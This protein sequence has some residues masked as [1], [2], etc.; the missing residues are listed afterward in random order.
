M[1]TWRSQ[2]RWVKGSALVDDEL[3]CWD[4]T[5]IKLEQEKVGGRRWLP[6]N[7]GVVEVER[8]VEIG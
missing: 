2:P 7:G 1:G 8:A 5:W 4:P 3:E 6:D